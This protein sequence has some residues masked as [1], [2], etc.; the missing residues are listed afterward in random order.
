MENFKVGDII[1]EKLAFGKIIGFNSEGLAVAEW[2]STGDFGVFKEDD[3][4]LI[5]R[6]EEEEDGISSEN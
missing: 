4:H 2:A 3:M 5:E 1:V 6:P